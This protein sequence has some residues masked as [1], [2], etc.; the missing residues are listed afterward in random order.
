MFKW[1]ME[2]Q[3]SKMFRSN[4]LCIFLSMKFI[5]TSIQI[6][7]GWIH[8][9]LTYLSPCVC[10]S[11]TLIS[12]LLYLVTDLSTV[13]GKKELFK[14]AVKCSGNTC[15]SGKVL[16]KPWF[17]YFGSLSFKDLFRKLSHFNLCQMH[18]HCIILY[19]MLVSVLIFA[20]I[21]FG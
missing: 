21:I 3:N 8:F 13:Q 14:P 7:F 11:T 6:T 17:K 16:L 20:S 2:R 18:I 5:S 9:C 15:M 1:P 10:N 4:V 12:A 19:Y